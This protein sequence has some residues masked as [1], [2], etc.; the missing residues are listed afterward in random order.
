MLNIHVS[1]VAQGDARQLQLVTILLDVAKSY[2]LALY[3]HFE[4]S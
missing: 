3:K 1:T 4:H 2:T